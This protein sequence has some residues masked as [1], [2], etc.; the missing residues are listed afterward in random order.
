MSF[1][2]VRDDD[3][4]ENFIGSPTT[5]ETTSE[6]KSNGLAKAHK[7]SLILSK[8]QKIIL[9]FLFWNEILHL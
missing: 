9:F 8:N 5:F 3:A 7:D 2:F 1:G 4:I 6:N